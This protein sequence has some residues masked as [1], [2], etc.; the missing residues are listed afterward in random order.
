MRFD[1]VLIGIEVTLK[2]EDLRQHM[3][4]SAEVVGQTLASIAMDYERE[5]SAGYF[6]AIE[7]FR[8]RD[9]VDPELIK[10]AETVSWLVAKLARQIIQKRLKPI[11][12]SVQIQ[13]AQN[14]AF[15]LPRVRPRKPGT[16]KDLSRHYAPD[17]V[18]FELLLT[19]M[20]KDTDTNDDRAEPYAR[21]MMFRWLESEFAHVEITSSKRLA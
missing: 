3:P 9:E 6:P 20:R 11:F 16:E 21:K 5:N 10:S 14:T 4:C 18:K 17:S 7:F 2:E 13:S 15:S 12:S 1:K 19:M 8:E